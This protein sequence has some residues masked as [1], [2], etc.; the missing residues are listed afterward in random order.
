PAGHRPA[1]RRPRPGSRPWRPRRRA[2]PPRRGGARAARSPSWGRLR[3]LRLAGAAVR[4]DEL[5]VSAEPARDRIGRRAGQQ[6][7]GALHEDRGRTGQDDLVARLDHRRRDPARDVGRVGRGHATALRPLGHPRARERRHDEREAH[8][9]GVVLAPQRAREAHDGVLGRA[10]GRHPRSHLAAGHRGH[11]HDLAAAAREHRREREPHAAHHAVHV[12]GEHQLGQ[13]R[14]LGE[15][16]PG[17]HD[18]GV[19]DEH[20][21]APRLAL[22]RRD[23]RGERVLVG[24]V[25]GEGAG[26]QPRGLAFDEV[27]VEI[28]EDDARAGVTQRGRSGQPD[29]AC[30]ARN[31]DRA[32]G[33]RTVRRHGASLRAR[34]ATGKAHAAESEDEMSAPCTPPARPRRASCAQRCTVRDDPRVPASPEIRLADELER[35]SGAYA[36]LV[37]DRIA[38][39]V[40]ELLADERKRDLARTG[41]QALLREFATALRH[42][43][44]S[45][46]YHAPTAALAYGRHLAH[47]GVSLPAILRSYR[48]GQEVLFARAAQ[49]ALEEDSGDEAV[50]SLAR[51]GAL[52]FRFSD[53]AMSDVAHEYETQRELLIRGTLAQ[54]ASTLQALLAGRAV[55][56]AAAER[57]LGHRLDGAHLAIVAWSADPAIAG[58]AI[59]GAARELVRAV[60]RGRPLVVTDTPGEATIWTAPAPRPLERSVAALL[61]P[62]I[63]AAIGRPGSGVDGFAATRRQADLARAAAGHGD[64]PA[65]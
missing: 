40:P 17:R 14:R 48:L 53:G 33:Q 19:V 37:F 52:S 25:E 11:I 29:P 4:G 1:R 60:G 61:P 43:L 65:V 62:G 64:G 18:A 5:L 57:T 55:D 10:V 8:P 31:G 63:R 23:E 16:A 44:G 22:G 21:E 28:A 13:G 30:G 15:E 46:H 3:P 49:L 56:V 39:E 51:I 32:T 45:I 41:S 7:L 36:E 24:D 58:E 6:P 26:A 9:G 59:A 47:E 2:R 34:T 12:H 20:V 35:N 42:E 50:R 27:A 38:A 54:R